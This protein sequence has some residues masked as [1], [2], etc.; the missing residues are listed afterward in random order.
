MTIKRFDDFQ[1]K[2]LYFVDHKSYPN[3]KTCTKIFNCKHNKY[4]FSYTKII[5]IDEQLVT[6]KEQ[7]ILP[8]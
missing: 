7:P 5:I 3:S 8:D 1:V 2:S 4:E 6:K